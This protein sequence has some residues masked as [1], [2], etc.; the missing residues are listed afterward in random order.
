MSS[1]RSASRLPMSKIDASA[2]Y[3][4]CAS[5]VAINSVSAS[6]LPGSGRYVDNAVDQVRDQPLIRVAGRCGLRRRDVAR[7]EIEQRALRRH[8]ARGH[9]E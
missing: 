7:I 1:V 9:V 6:P 8:P 3:A 4:R 5:S 2:S